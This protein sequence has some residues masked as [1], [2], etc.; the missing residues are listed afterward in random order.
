MFHCSSSNSIRRSNSILWRHNGIFVSEQPR[1]TPARFTGRRLCSSRDVGLPHQSFGETSSPTS[2]TLLTRSPQAFVSPLPLLPE[3]IVP[4]HPHLIHLIPVRKQRTTVLKNR[5]SLSWLC[6][7]LWG[8]G[9]SWCFW[10]ISLFLRRKFRFEW[11]SSVFCL[12]CEPQH[13]DVAA[14]LG[15]VSGGGYR[16][17]TSSISPPLS[18]THVFP[19]PPDLI[20]WNQ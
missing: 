11:N 9:A 1:S 4:C 20:F 14:L 17:R 3:V 10:G 19:K 7:C 5:T 6:V 13:S 2:K 16:P 18:S 12:P 8:V 15:G